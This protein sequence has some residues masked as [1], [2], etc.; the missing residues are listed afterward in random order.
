MSG[1]RELRDFG[2]FA[3]PALPV[4]TAGAQVADR[5]NLVAV[6]VVDGIFT[7]QQ[8]ALADLADHRLPS[9]LEFSRRHPAE[10]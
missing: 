9:E 7:S 6:V 2:A 4:S 10:A 8:A 1:W 5:V 3:N